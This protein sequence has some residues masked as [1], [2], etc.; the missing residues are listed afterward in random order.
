MGLFLWNS[1]LPH[2]MV[3]WM[4]T[5][6][7][8]VFNAICSTFLP[9]WGKIHTEIGCKDSAVHCT[10]DCHCWCKKGSSLEVVRLSAVGETFIAFPIGNF[11]IENIY[12]N[13]SQQ[14]LW[15]HEAE[16]GVHHHHHHLK[17]KQNGEGMEKSIT[18]RLIKII[19]R[20][21]W[22]TV[23]ES[24]IKLDVVTSNAQPDNYLSENNKISSHCYTRLLGVERP[25]QINSLNSSSQKYN[26][27]Y[28]IQSQE[29]KFILTGRECGFH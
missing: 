13:L 6:K 24:F 10:A 7:Y 18:S 2:L 27:R 29:S 12:R 16:N 22:V 5:D 17:V 1:P 8:F 14:Q 19:L 23:R 26:P 3:F 11:H 4:C 28:L 21:D 15:G 20:L 25:S 9:F